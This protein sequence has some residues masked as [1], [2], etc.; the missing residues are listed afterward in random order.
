MIPGPGDRTGVCLLRS[1][2][3]ILG[4]PTSP[5]LQLV[6]GVEVSEDVRNDTLSLLRE[7]SP[8]ALASLLDTYQH[9]TGINMG[10]RKEL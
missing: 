10:L 8:P 6:L 2:P 5:F 4:L 3:G 9:S 7:P 1:S